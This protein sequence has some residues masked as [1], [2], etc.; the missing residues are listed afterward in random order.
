MLLNTLVKTVKRKSHRGDQAVTTDQITL[1]ILACLSEAIRD[2]SK[3]LPKRYWHKTGTPLS[4][5]LGVAGTP[6]VYSLASDCQEPVAFHYVD[7]AT[8]YNL[9]KVDSDSEWLRKIWN[10]NASVGKPLYYREIG[11]DANGYKQ[12][13]V[14]PI[15][16]GSILLQNE[17][18]RTKGSDLTTSDLASEIPYIPDHVQD[19]VEKGGLYYFLKGF[20]DSLQAVAKTDYMEAKQ[21]MNESDEADFDADLRMR[22]D[23]QR[24]YFGDSVRFE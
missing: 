7:G 5:T 9:S 19:V 16:D 18:Y 13:E 14:F 23:I 8:Y 6:A 11:P 4:L 10:P 17:Y 21:A 24:P 1:D 22:W 15:P 3:L 20:D 2:V 12:I